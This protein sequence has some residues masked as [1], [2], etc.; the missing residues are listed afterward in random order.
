MPKTAVPKPLRRKPKTDP[1]NTELT[2]S[3]PACQ[4]Q[5]ILTQRGGA[6][7]IAIWIDYSY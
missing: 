2:K 3:I 1:E 6:K 4:K 7:P 5:L